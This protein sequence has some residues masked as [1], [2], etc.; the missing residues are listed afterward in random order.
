MTPGHTDAPSSSWLFL[1]ESITYDPTFSHFDTAPPLPIMVRVVASNGA[2]EPSIEFT[3][4]Q[5]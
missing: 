3:I 2:N 5:V 1:F 4:K